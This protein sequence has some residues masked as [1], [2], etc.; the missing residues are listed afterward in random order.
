LGS[1][2]DVQVSRVDL[3]GRRI[4]FRLVTDGELAPARSPS[5]KGKVKGKEVDGSEQAPRSRQA[6]SGPKAKQAAA[7]SN[8]KG[9]RG[10]G[11]KAA[12]GTSSKK[13]RR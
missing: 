11:P 13:A 9:D 2:V 12:R 3:D 6:R 7:P 4:D 1:R 10:S 5:S 8:K